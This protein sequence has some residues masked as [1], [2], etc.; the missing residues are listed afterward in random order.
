MPPRRNLPMKSRNPE[1][2]R[3]THNLLTRDGV[4]PIRQ[5]VEAGR[6]NKAA[7][8]AIRQKQIKRKT[9]RNAQ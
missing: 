6:L 1:I 5:A 7:A 8:K 2:R 9:E 3:K 4:K